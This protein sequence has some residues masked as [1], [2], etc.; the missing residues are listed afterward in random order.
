[1]FILTR[2]WETAEVKYHGGGGELN[3]I[4]EFFWS[5]YGVTNRKFKKLPL[6]N[7]NENTTPNFTI[8]SY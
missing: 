6:H 2:I 5:F 4:K 8:I 3:Q 7:E 1:M